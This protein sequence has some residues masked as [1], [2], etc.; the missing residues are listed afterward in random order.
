M[1]ALLVAPHARASVSF[2]VLLDALVG[3]STAA[4]VATPVETKSVWEDGRIATY[5]RVHVDRVLAGSAASEVWVKTL[6]GVVGHIGQQVEGEA[7]LRAGQQSVL[8]LTTYEGSIVVTARGQGQFPIVVDG[9]VLRLRKNQHA[10]A[11]L[12]VRPSTLTRIRATTA[13]ANASLPAGDVLDGKSIDD[14][15]IE[16]A[17]SWQRTHAHP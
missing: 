4:C 14:A 1:V 8:F 2:T 6:G 16:I 11:L 13:I 10:G 7:V 12:G 5:T 3:E 17:A 15:Q 9:S